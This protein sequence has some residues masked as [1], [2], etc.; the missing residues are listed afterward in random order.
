MVVVDGIRVGN[1][2]SAINILVPERL[3]HFVYLRA[4]EA[5]VLFGTGAHAGVLLAF[6]KN[7]EV[8]RP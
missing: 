6:T 7:Y 1:P 8:A 3:S 5:G 2:W 4:S